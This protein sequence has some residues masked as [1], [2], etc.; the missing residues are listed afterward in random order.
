MGHWYNVTNVSDNC[1]WSLILIR[2]CLTVLRWESKYVPQNIH[3]KI[4]EK[5]PFLTSINSFHSWNNEHNTYMYTSVQIW[6][7]KKSIFKKI[8]ILLGVHCM[9]CGACS[10][11][12][13][14][15]GQMVNVELILRTGLVLLMYLLSYL[16]E[17]KIWDIQFKN[18]F[19]VLAMYILWGILKK[20]NILR[21]KFQNRNFWIFNF[22]PP[23]RNYKGSP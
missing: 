2:H 14:D 11:I 8:C 19:R 5:S 9:F 6:F 22:Q 17:E 1:Q 18:F 12:I 13:D 3:F 21:A 7:F 15:D 20:P 10:K 16:Y 4:F 23:G